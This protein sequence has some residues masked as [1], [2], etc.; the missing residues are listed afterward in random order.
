MKSKPKGAKYRNLYAWRGSIWYS[1]M[2]R[3]R[4]YRVN[5]DAPTSR[6]GWE[7]AALFRDKYEEAKGIGQPGRYAG[8][9]PTLTEFAKRYLDEDTGT[10]ALTTRQDRRNHLGSEGPLLPHLGRRRLDEITP[11]ML[12]EWWG[13]VVEGRGRKTKTGREYLNTLAAV[14]NY[15]R[16]LGLL[17]ETPIPAFRGI[18]RR[19]TRTQRGRAEADTGRDLRPIEDAALIERLVEEARQEGPEALVYVLLGLDAGLRL[20]ESLGLRWGAIMWGRDEDDTSRHL[21]IIESRPRGGPPGPPKSGR[22]RSVALSRRL[23]AALLQ[24]Y[25]ARWQ[26]SD[27]EHLLNIDPSNY[28]AREWRLIR[29]RA[30]AGGLR[31]K[32][33]RDTYAS[34][35]LT[36]GVQLGYVSRQ[37]GHADVA[38]TAKHYAR[39]VAGDDYRD[40]MARQT[41]ELPADFLARLLTNC[42]HDTDA[43]HDGAAKLVEM[44]GVRGGPPG[45]RTLDHR[46]KSPVLYQLS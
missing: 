42:S 11:P 25:R 29:Q 39:W 13:L 10:L 4:R 46:V 33:L 38:V 9:M 17:E 22:A 8:A 15:A 45:T 30:K 21:R 32:D 12:R 5:T 18:L 37:I 16:D 44:R 40:P 2:V 3:G 14:L 36:A 35:L 31:Y 26:P 27:D 19:R 7:E 41:G 28:N 24:L 34:Q 20:G 43:R 6:T 1:R 23:R